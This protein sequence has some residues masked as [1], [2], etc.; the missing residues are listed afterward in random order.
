MRD[1]NKVIVHCSDTPESMD[2]GAEEIYDWHVNERGWKDIGYHYVIRRSGLI[3]VGRM[4]SVQ[5][6]HCSG[7]NANSIGI[8]MVGR[9][10]FTGE[11][12]RSLRKLIQELNGR[13]SIIKITGHSTYNAHKTCPNFDVEG[14]WRLDE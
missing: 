13:Y 4:E 14:W 2:I 6:A 7:E 5:G 3:E 8:C 11:Q 9:S 12:F 10:G 1:I